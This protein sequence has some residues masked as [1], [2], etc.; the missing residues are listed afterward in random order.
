MEGEGKKCSDKYI[1]K[2]EDAQSQM[3]LP[4]HFEKLQTHPEGLPWLSQGKN[5]VF[6]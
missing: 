5:G 1:E 6:P 2:L 4:Y 3:E